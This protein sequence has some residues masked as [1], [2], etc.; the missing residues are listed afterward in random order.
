MSLVKLATLKRALGIADSAEDALLQEAEDRA[1][2]LIEQALERRFQTPAQVT[3]YRNGTGGSALFLG[4]AV[5]DPEAEVTVSERLLAYGSAWTLLADT[6]FEVRSPDRLV[7][8]DGIAWLIGA[9]YR[10]TYPS[11]YAEAPQDIQDLCIELV[12]K[13]RARAQGRQGLVSEGIGDYSYSFGP[14]ALEGSALSVTA[15]MT[16][17]RWRRMH[18]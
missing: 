7:R 9:E 5:E 15:R 14:E 17:N 16:V 6:A 8:L 12:G 1:T 11:G 10:I 3:E 13:A 4:G 2:A 18:V